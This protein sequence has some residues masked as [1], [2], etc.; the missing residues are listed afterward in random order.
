MRTRDDGVTGGRLLQHSRGIKMTVVAKFTGVLVTDWCQLSSHPVT[1]QA[2][3][4]GFSL[5]PA[6]EGQMEIFG[7]DQQQQPLHPLGSNLQH[8]RDE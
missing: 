7:E 1:P 4:G 2:S 5:D 6:E 3:A 8:R